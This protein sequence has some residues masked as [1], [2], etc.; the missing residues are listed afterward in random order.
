MAPRGKSTTLQ[1][2]LDVIAEIEKDEMVGK[3]KNNTQKKNTSKQIL[4][5]FKKSCNQLRRWHEW[6]MY[7]YLKKREDNIIIVQSLPLTLVPHY[8]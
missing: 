2:K 6:G 5:N 4:N 7:L 3:V 1:A 8:A